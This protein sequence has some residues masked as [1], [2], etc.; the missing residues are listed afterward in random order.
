LAA[1]RKKYLQKHT[2]CQAVTENGDSHFWQGL[3]EIKKFFWQH[4]KVQVGDGAKTN[5]REYQ[6]IGSSCLAKTFPRLFLVSM[7]KNVTVQE[8]F[9]KGWKGLGLEEKWLENL[10]SNGVR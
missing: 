5:F 1:I 10:E 6:W 7:N 4:Y 8:G 3:M 2:L 9:D